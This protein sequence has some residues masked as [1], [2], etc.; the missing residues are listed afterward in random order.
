MT[1]ERGQATPSLDPQASL[2]TELVSQLASAQ[3]ALE[4]A[5]ADLV[6]N[7]A[8]SAV[9][10]TSRSQLTSVITLRQ[11]IGVSSGSTLAHLRSEVAA[12][13]TAAAATAQQ[14]SGVSGN[15]DRAGGGMTPQA[16]RQTIETIG[17]DIFDRKVLDPYLQFSSKEDE[18]AYRKRERERKAEIDR[19]LA[20]HTPE[21]DQKAAELTHAQL[22]DAG[23]HG[24]DRSPDFAG[25]V[26]DN[27]AALTTLRAAKN[28][29]VEPAPQRDNKN[30]A[31]TNNKRD[32]SDTDLAGAI[33]AL[34]V[35][36]V[37][38]SAPAEE[39]GAQHGLAV[40]GQ[41][42]AKVKGGSARET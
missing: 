25:L 26:S 18:E 34:K 38:S 7:G 17:H 40:N 5:I 35:A 28:S 20:L 8:D 22:V 14:A 19:A 21:G 41:V 36:G 37:V 39:S 31:T 9:L 3:L 29:I 11:Q 4:A 23:A 27:D 1:V 30:T 13:A 12:A 15:A 33:E 16:A 10:A 24:A 6:R 2:R 32:D 42:H